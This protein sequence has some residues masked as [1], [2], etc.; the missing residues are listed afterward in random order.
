MKYTKL[1]KAEK[2]SEEAKQVYEKINTLAKQF[3]YSARISY[4]FDNNVL[5][6]ISLDGE[7]KLQPDIRI[8][9][10]N[11]EGKSEVRVQT[12]SY[13][14]L[15]LQDY[16]EFLNACNKAYECAQAFEKEYIK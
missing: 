8:D 10:K 13:G 15:N 7:S 1:I 11:F 4:D 14:S 16:Q 9:I 12:T 2:V 5:Y 3:G 6:G